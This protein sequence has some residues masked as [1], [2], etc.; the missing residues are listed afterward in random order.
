MDGA[1]FHYPCRNKHFFF[2][3]ITYQ[4][5]KWCSF[6]YSSIVNDGTLISNLTAAT[7]TKKE[8]CWL[9]W[10]K[11]PRRADSRGLH[12]GS[13][14]FKIC[15]VLCLQ[16]E[17]GCSSITLPFLTCLEPASSPGSFEHSFHLLAISTETSLSFSDSSKNPT[18]SACHW[19]LLDLLDL[20]Y[21]AC[22]FLT[23]V[24]KGIPCFIW[25]G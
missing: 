20:S 13:L 11:S 6:Q 17:A 15:S 10:Q 16:V 2:L 23:S 21:I 7:A 9:K 24:V 5:I 19:V 1:E 25:P 22:L 4:V 14:L 3:N 18:R 8:M 12:L